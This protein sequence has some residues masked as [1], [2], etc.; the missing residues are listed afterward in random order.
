MSLAGRVC[1][2]TGAS[3]GIGKGIALQLGEA[4]A[5]VYITGTSHLMAHVYIGIYDFVQFEKKGYLICMV[6]KTP[7]PPAL[8]TAALRGLVFFALALLSQA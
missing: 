1:V 8:V 4:G 6:T 7:V 2:V 5:T 3:R